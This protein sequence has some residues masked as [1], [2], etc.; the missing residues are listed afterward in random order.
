MVAVG[1]WHRLVE[2]CSEGFQETSDPSGKRYLGAWLY[3]TNL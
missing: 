2:A 1:G 3:F